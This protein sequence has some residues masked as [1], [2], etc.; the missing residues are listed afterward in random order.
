MEKGRKE[1]SMGIQ[2]GRGAVVSVISAFLTAGVLGGLP[3]KAG[4]IEA[5]SMPLRMESKQS[6][7]RASMRKL[8]ADH[9]IWTREYIVA[10]IGGN[11]DA[12][13]VATR[14]LR[15]QAEIG[16]AFVPYYG[17]ETGAKLAELL[18][19]HILTAAEV[20]DGMKTSNQGKFTDANRRWHDNANDIA[21]LLSD[22]NPGWSKKKMLGMFNDHLALT[23]HES[24]SRLNKKWADDIAVFDK[25]FREVMMM[26]DDLSNG[27]I[28]QFP[29]KFR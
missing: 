23:T 21:V 3:A 24:A 19:Q 16:H 27:V 12:A 26:A 10:A 22:A 29:E 9:V 13:D 25:I 20:I 1:N 7:F 15:N 5:D 2:T 17:E 4:A 6:L 18:K 14:L 8:W 28:E 11:P